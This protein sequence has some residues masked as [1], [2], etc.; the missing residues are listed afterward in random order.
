[1][2]NLLTTT[3][4]MFAVQMSVQAQTFNQNLSAKLQFTLDSLVTLFS[5]NGNTKGISVSIY[6]PGQGY[7]NGVSGISHTGV[8]LTADMRL[9]IASNSKLF[10]AVTMVRLAEDGILSLDDQLNEWLPDY[11]N[12][13]PTITIRQLLNHSSG[14][15]DPFFGT[16][17]LDTIEVDPDRVFTPEEILTWVGAP[18]FAQGTDYGYSNT[19]YILSGMIALNATGMHISQL[20]RNYILDPLEMNGTFYDIEEEETG[21]LAHRWHNGV[22]L[23]DTSRVSLNTAGGSSGSLFSTA[24]DMTKWYHAL[25]NNEVIS[26]NSFAELTTFINPGNYG[27]GIQSSVFFG[28]TVWGHGGSTF[29]YKSRMIY[30]PCNKTIVCGLANSDFA[31]I[32]GITALLYKVL[33]DNLPDCAG[34]ITGPLILCQGEQGITYTVPEITHAESYSWILPNGASGVSLTNSITVDY[35][36]TAVSGDLSVKGMSSYGE[37]AASVLPVTVNELPATPV[38]SFDDVTLHSDA[39][40]GNQWYDQN[41]PIAGETGQDFTV[42]ANGNYY[43]VVTLSDCS[44]VPSNQIDIVALSTDENRLN[45]LHIFPNPISNEL[46][47]EFPGNEKNLEYEITNAVG[48]IIAQGSLL[49]RVTVLTGGFQ[50]GI[51]LVKIENGAL[52]VIRKVV[53]E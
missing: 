52:P 21:V 8:N 46:V 41:G 13:N 28:R 12:I 9:G 38:I 35:G 22:D 10:T 29:G 48:Q 39:P 37:G 34:E 26:E 2:K 6:C 50:P 51:Y 30:D 14:I 36:L 4:L 44:S 5:G 27:L 40:A 17:L 25:M 47:L 7:W 53:K 42:P 43:T 49:Q 19:N 33:L 31:A 24:S 32:D 45:S 23:H 3:L 1:M 20:I 16:A 18:L 15:S 11:P